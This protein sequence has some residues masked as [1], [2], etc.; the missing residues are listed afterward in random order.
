MVKMSVSV[1]VMEI[2]NP[3]KVETD[4]RIA[5]RDSRTKPIDDHRF[6]LCNRNC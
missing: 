6:G 2:V 4:G 3:S 5:I 1:R